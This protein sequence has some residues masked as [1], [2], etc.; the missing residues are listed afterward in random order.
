LLAGAGILGILQMA[1]SVWALVDQWDHKAQRRVQILRDFT[2][3]RAELARFNP[4]ANGQYDQQR[5]GELEYR[6]GLGLY[7]DN[8]FDIPIEVRT[9][10]RN[11]AEARYK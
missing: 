10:T 1:A 3:L 6:A 2:Q 5:L 7:C 4:D 11:E 9:R 8:E